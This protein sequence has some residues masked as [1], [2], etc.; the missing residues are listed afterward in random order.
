[1]QHVD[2][3]EIAPGYSVSRVIKGSWQLAG[4]H[5]LVDAERAQDDMRRFVEAGITTFDGADIYTGV[6][7]L[8]GGFLKRFRDAFRTGDLP[9]VQV[10][11]KCVP[12]LDDLPTLRRGDVEALVDR[13][14]RRLGVER[15]DLVQLHWWDYAV[16]GYVAA[17]T[18]LRRLQKAGKIRHLGVTN[19]DALHLREILDEGIPIVSNQVQ[20]SIVD[21]RPETDLTESCRENGISLLAYGSVAGGF[22]SER[23]L[24]A[25]E[26]RPPYENRSL[27]K[28]KLILD[29]FGDWRIVQALLDLLGGIARRYGV[30]LAAV[31]SRYVLQ[32]PHVASV[33]VGAR[34]TR[35]LAET[36]GLF[37][38]RLS[39]DDV[40]SIDAVAGS[41]PNGPVYGLERLREGP[42]GVIMLYNLNR[43]ADR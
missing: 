33:I 28:Y 30:S 16:P 40:A 17:A 9:A 21:R 15:L 34:N 1:M 4:G 3:I 31:A 6:E 18:W 35:H 36:A 42:H 38:F 24:N 37:S 7:E 39:R 12:D 26:P 19:F 41:G 5:G 25:G 10:H 14:L 22:L 23:Y 20:Y 2:R 29:E 8:I 13:S 11:T 43:N 32:R 27:T